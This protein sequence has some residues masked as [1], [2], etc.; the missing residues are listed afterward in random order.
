MEGAVVE[1]L[2]AQEV[3]QVVAEGQGKGYQKKHF[4][5][6]IIVVIIIVEECLF[7]IIQ[8]MVDLEQKVVGIQ[9]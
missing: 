1:V 7:L 5:D 8:R 4:M 3:L 6:A 9:R 2:V